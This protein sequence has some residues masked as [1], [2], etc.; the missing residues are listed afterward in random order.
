MAVTPGYVGSSSI[1]W[2]A[3]ATATVTSAS[4]GTATWDRLVLVGITVEETATINTVT[5]GGIT[6]TSAISVRNTTGT[7]DNAVAF[8]YARVP[9]GTTGNIVVTL[10]ASSSQTGVMSVW[11]VTGALHHPSAP[12]AARVPVPR[13]RSLA[14]PSRLAVRRSRPSTTPLPARQSP[15]RTRPSGTILLIAARPTGTVC[16]HYDCWHADRHC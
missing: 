6:A 5:I 14:S 7:P 15:G 2:S 8:F 12:T 9:T 1:T 10:S 16:G 4:I 13:R 11:A 3:S